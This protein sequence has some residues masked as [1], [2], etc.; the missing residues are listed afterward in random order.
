MNNNTGIEAS[1]KKRKAVCSSMLMKTVRNSKKMEVAM[2]KH[3]GK[4][5]ER[6]VDMTA[7]ESVSEVTN[8]SIF[9]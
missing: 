1:A 2:T 8:A 6:N 7:K 4:G 5:T 3:V 9:I